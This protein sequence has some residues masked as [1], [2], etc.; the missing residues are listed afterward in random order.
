[1][2]NKLPNFIDKHVGRRLRWRRR[3]LRLSQEALAAKLGLTFQQVQKYE[4]GA[5]RISAGRLFELARALD[6][7]IAYFYEG[8]DAVN[9]AV[10]RG[11]AEDGP[12]FAGLIDADAVDLVIAFQAIGDPVLR[13]SILTMVKNSAALF[14]RP[15][16]A[17][18]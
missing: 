15:V 12:E 18:E 3:E 8:A 5:N 10:M 11:M 13:R 6:T 1:M 16:P 14:L 9:Q 17:G 2:E 7:S 4:R